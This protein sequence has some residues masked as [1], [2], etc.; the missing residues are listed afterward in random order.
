MKQYLQYFKNFNPFLVN[1]KYLQGVPNL[2]KDFIVKFQPDKYG[3]QFSDAKTNSKKF[4][5]DR[6][7]LIKISVED[8]STIES[9]VGFKRLLLVGLFAFAWKKRSQIP[10]SFLVFEFRDEFDGNQ[11]MYIQSDKKTGFQDFTNIKYNLQKFWNEAEN[12]PNYETEMQEFQNKV[13]MQSKMKTRIVLIAI[14]ILLIIWLF[15]KLN[16]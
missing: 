7:D 10:L 4:Y 8:Q 3:I 15:N 2:N 6:N 14:G 11:E 1:A 12:N 9:R 5:L 16:N 13:N